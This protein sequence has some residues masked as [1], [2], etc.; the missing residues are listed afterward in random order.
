MRECV[1]GVEWS[2]SG[3]ALSRAEHGTATYAT[4]QSATTR[5]G[6]V[7]SR[8][9]Y[10]K[11]CH[12]RH[13]LSIVSCLHRLET[14]TGS[15]RAGRGGSSAVAAEPSD[16]PLCSSSTACCRGLPG[17]RLVSASGPT[18]E[19]GQV[20]AENSSPNLESANPQVQARHRP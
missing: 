1:V 12:G 19:N 17:F 4:S 18:R 11:S 3:R 8:Q 16:T 14:S 9:R 6:R 2:V 7:V 5:H 13:V 15:A 10:H 20:S